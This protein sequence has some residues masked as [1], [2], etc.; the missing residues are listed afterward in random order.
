MSQIYDPASN[1]LATKAA[2]QQYC[3]TKESQKETKVLKK[4]KINAQKVA[5][6]FKCSARKLRS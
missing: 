2:P 3:E 5:N 1:L 6:L 4:T